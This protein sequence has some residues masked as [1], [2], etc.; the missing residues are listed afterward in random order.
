MWGRL[1]ACT[2]LQSRWNGS[3]EPV[4][5][6]LKPRRRLEACPTWSVTCILRA[7]LRMQRLGRAG[8]GRV[9]I[10][11]PIA[12]QREFFASVDHLGPVDLDSEELLFDGAGLAHDFPARVD[13]H[14]LA[15]HVPLAFAP[16]VV[17]GGEV[18][19]VFESARR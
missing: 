3:Q 13:N 17:A 8:D 16:H 2:G 1:I 18:D 19:S 6:G 7:P 14:A 11:P 10:R 5:G 9:G 4:G 15:G 12:K